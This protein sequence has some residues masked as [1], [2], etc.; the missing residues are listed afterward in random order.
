M[1]MIILA[2]LDLYDVASLTYIKWKEP[3][4]A[5]SG[6]FAYRL[7]WLLVDEG[8][9]DVDHDDHGSLIEPP[10]GVSGHSLLPAAPVLNIKGRSAY[11]LQSCGA[12]CGRLGSLR[13]LSSMITNWLLSIDPYKLLTS[14][15]ALVE[16]ENDGFVAGLYEIIAARLLTHVEDVAPLTDDD[17][18]DDRLSQLVAVSATAGSYYY[19][20]LIVAAGVTMLG[21]FAYRIQWMEPPVAVSGSTYRSWLHGVMGPSVGRFAYQLHGG[22]SL[23]EV[24]SLTTFG[25]ARF[26]QPVAMQVADL[27]PPY[28]PHLRV[29]CSIPL[30]SPKG[31]PKDEGALRVG[32]YGEGSTPVT[33]ASPPP[34]GYAN[35]PPHSSPEL[36]RPPLIYDP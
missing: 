15:L 10:V 29:P 4:V 28:P 1:F 21:R 14:P 16:T 11:R 12:A 3:P 9:D 24:A 6:R 31:A 23:H 27:I 26:A 13:L 8:D 36:K 19:S 22:L 33:T 30:I 17:P 2:A 25:G 7:N 5:V 34:L 20:L 18:F 35:T 32:H